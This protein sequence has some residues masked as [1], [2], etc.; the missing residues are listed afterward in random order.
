MISKA[1]HK[2]GR[3]ADPAVGPDGYFLELSALILYWRV[4]VLE[5]MLPTTT[6]NMNTTAN[7]CIFT[8][9]AHTNITLGA[10]I[11]P[12]LI[13]VSRWD[14]IVRKP[15]EISSDVSGQASR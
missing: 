6:K 5:G 3:I 1:R 12:R 10:D 7:Q 9:P 15:T 11:D 4:G 8:D 13:L 2:D 14:R